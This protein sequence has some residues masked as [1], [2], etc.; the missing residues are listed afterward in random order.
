MRLQKINCN[1]GIVLKSSRKNQLSSLKKSVKI[2]QNIFAGLSSKPVINNYYSAIS[3]NGAV[4]AVLKKPQILDMGLEIVKTQFKNLIQKFPGDIKYYTKMASDMGLPK[5]QEFRLFSVVGKEQLTSILTHASRQDF[6]IGH[7]FSG[8]KNLTHRINLHNHTQA[9]DGALSVTEFLNQARKYA[10]KVA[11]KNPDKPY[12]VAITDHDILDGAQEAVRVIAQNPYKYRNLRLVTGS[13]ISV[14][15]INPED[16]KAPLDFELILYSANPFNQHFNKFLQ[17]VRDGRN[18]TA[19]IMLDKINQEI[20]ELKLNWQEAG[21][22]TPNLGKGTSNG[23]IWLARDYAVSK[24]E[25]FSSAETKDSKIRYVN[26]LK[27][28][29]LKSE[30]SIINPEITITPEQVF[31]AYAKSSDFGLLGIAH[32]GRLVIDP[33]RMCSDKIMK[34]CENSYRNPSFHLAWRLFNRL[35]ILGLRVSEAN[36]QAYSKQGKDWID[37]MNKAS[38]RLGLLE[39]GGTDC[40]TK[41]LFTHHKSIPLPVIDELN[42]GDVVGAA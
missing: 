10:D 37:F 12:F 38:K 13:E 33:Q 15:H 21:E 27:D 23:S 6:E 2:Q 7:D 34:E 4:P 18:K 35:K 40:H 26:K 8:V 29:Y 11:Q 17:K 31:E 39:A 42:L 5:G 19:K 24:I 32:P 1:E 36:Y 30:K 41:H 28:E 20:P 3:F 25:K 22:F 14:S 9:S 16:V